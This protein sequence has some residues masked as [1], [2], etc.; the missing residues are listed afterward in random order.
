[1]ASSP[2]RANSQARV[3]IP[4]NAHGCARAVSHSDSAN[5]TAPSAASATARAAATYAGR[6]GPPTTRDQRDRQHQ[7]RPHDVELLLDPERPEVQHRARRRVRG[8]VVGRLRG[9]ADVGHVEGR[10]DHVEAHAAVVEPRQREP[11]EHGDH[12]EDQGRGGQQPAGPTRPEAGERHVAVALHLGDQQA[13]DEEAGDH[14]EHVD[15]DEA[16]AEQRQPH[17]VAD[18]G[19][20]RDRPQA[21]DVRSEA[22][23]R[24]RVG[25]AGRGRRIPH[26]WCTRDAAHPRR[27]GAAYADQRSSRASTGER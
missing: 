19:D 1:M 22:P 18:D 10:C 4:K 5:E 21:F 27:I 24:G 2:P 11:R 12:A 16:A 25:R 3:G 8:E 13:G 26:R 14:E 15:A 17:V 6:V 7:Q 23:R 9:E 20:D